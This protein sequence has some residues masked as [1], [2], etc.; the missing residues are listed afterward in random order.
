MR[1]ISPAGPQSNDQVEAL[2]VKLFDSNEKDLKSK[3][4]LSVC[5]AGENIEKQRRLTKIDS[6][7]ELLTPVNDT[8]ALQS[9]E[10]EEIIICYNDVLKRLGKA[11]N[12]IR[13]L[14]HSVKTSQDA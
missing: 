2:Q 14:R 13:S 3:R 4:S 5:S 8:A 7:A 11:S 6:L 1:K 9:M 10:H 12:E